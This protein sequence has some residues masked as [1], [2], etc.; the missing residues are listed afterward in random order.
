MLRLTRVLAFLAVALAGLAMVIS[1][2]RGHHRW[3]LW[4]TMRLVLQGQAESLVVMPEG[5]RVPSLLHH[6]AMD[7]RHI[8]FANPD[9]ARN[10]IDPAKPFWVA[11]LPFSVQWTARETLGETVVEHSLEITKAGRSRQVPV[12]VD[13]SVSPD[14]KAWRVA[15]AGVWEGVFPDPKGVPMASLFLKGDGGD[16]EGPVIVESG[17]LVAYDDLHLALQ[18]HADEAE[19]RRNCLLPPVPEPHWGVEDADGRFH[20]LTGFLPGTGV[21][22]ADGRSVT[23]VEHRT[24]PP[25]LLVEFRGP[26]GARLETVLANQETSPVRFFA[27]GAGGP[28][29]GLHVWVDGLALPVWYAG[30]NAEALEILAGGDILTLPGSGVVCMLETVRLAAIR[31]DAA[32]SPYRA[33]TLECEGTLV[34][35]REGERRQIGDAEVRYLPRVERPASRHTLVLSGPSEGTAECMLEEGKPCTLGDYQLVLLGVSSRRDDQLELLVNRRV[36]AWVVWAGV[37]LLAGALPGLWPGTVGAVWNLML[38]WRG[39]RGP[40][41]PA[42]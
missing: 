13:D 14:G 20:A 40:H 1:G 15:G 17:T 8:P 12:D 29:L 21:D 6:K 19:A 25:S 11:R 32:D 16:L 33:L 34:Y 23:L 7:G 10:W 27:P 35:L 36:P 5:G 22:L 39:K 31:V 42:A 26:D 4:G 41:P 24:D 3:Y 38:S 30:G 18:Q 9:V 28:V 2:T 37:A